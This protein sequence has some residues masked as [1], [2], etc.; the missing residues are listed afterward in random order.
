MRILFITLTLSL[1]FASVNA[2]TVATPVKVPADTPYTPTTLHHKPLYE[3]GKGTVGF[4]CGFLLGPVGWLGVRVFS[5][6]RTQR[7]KSVEGMEALGVVIFLVGFLYLCGKTGS[8]PN[9]FSSHPKRGPRKRAAANHGLTSLRPIPQ[10]PATIS[11]PDPIS[12]FSPVH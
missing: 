12:V 11:A 4:L 9:F 7:K 5:H 6:N 2:A 3:K 10:V 1:L 8:S